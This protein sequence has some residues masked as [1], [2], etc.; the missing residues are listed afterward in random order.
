MT[1]S[2]GKSLLKRFRASC[3]PRRGILPTSAHRGRPWGEIAAEVGGKPDARR[4]QLERAV[5]RVTRELRL[6]T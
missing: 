6:E 5:N 4:V 1:R 3:P 2:Q